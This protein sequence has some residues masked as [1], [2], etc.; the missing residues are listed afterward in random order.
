MAKIEK[1]A[2]LL[3]IKDII[4]ASDA[5]M[6]ARGDLGLSLMPPKGTICPKRLI[7]QCR[8]VGKPVVVATQMLE[9]MIASP[10]PTRAEATDVAGAVFDGADTVML[11]AET[12][13]GK[14]PVEVVE[15]MA[16]YL[17][18]LKTT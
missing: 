6:I 15:T 10:T 2:A 14:Y 5:I 9:S 12:A 1:P 11:S 18:Q 16:I 4:N 3:E 13:I 8:K 7:Y 17:F